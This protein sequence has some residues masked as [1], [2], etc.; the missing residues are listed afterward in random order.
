MMKTKRKQPQQ[1][2]LQQLDLSADFLFCKVMSDP[3]ICRITLEKILGIPIKKVGIPGSQ[4]VID[5]LLDSKGVRLDIYVEDENGTIY[6]CEMQTGHKT[7]LPKRS[8]YY[9]G[10]IDLDLISAGATYQEMRKTFIIFICTFD[11]FKQSRH[12]YTFENTCKEDP[13]LSLGDETVKVFLNTQG[14]LDDVDQDMK[15]FLAYV[16]NTTDTFANNAQSTWVKQIHKRVMEVKRS[17]EME[18]EY[19]TL[20]QRDR[21][22]VELGMAKGEIKGVK[23]MSSLMQ[24]L[25]E[26]NRINDMNE[27]LKDE[28]YLNHLFE[29]FGI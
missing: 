4:R 23:K 18:V 7:E 13:T 14:T 1:K 29:E 21:E 17:K 2:L 28:A 24:L 6:N 12:I 9:Q 20:L 16:E 11:P 8:R 25:L 15:E 19:M 27:A 10:C 3:E 5:I 26:A 22:N